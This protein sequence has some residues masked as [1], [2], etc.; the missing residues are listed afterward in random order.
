MNNL[1]NM[2]ISFGDDSITFSGCYVN[3]AHYNVT[4]NTLKVG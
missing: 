3:K 2:E 4:G 1:K